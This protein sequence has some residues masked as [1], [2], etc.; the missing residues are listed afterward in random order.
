MCSNGQNSTRAD[1]CFQAYTIHTP[2][3]THG[4]GSNQNKI[5]KSCFG[6]VCNWEILLCKST[7]K[8]VQSVI[9]SSGMMLLVRS[10]EK[11]ERKKTNRSVKWIVYISHWLRII[12]KAAILFTHPAFSF[13]STFHTELCF[14]HISSLTIH[15]NHTVLFVYYI[16]DPGTWWKN[17]ICSLIAVC[18]TLEKQRLILKPKCLGE[19]QRMTRVFF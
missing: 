13:F 1:S 11:K 14:R 17:R 19:C 4:A 15:L 5:S 8:H 9:N 16:I 7:W 3:Q 10:W 18:L 2:K 12:L 6:C